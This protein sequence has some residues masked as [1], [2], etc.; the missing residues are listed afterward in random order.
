MR[1]QPGLRLQ[2]LRVARRSWRCSASISD[3]GREQKGPA[4]DGAACS[5]LQRADPQLTASHSLVAAP[6]AAAREQD[7]RKP[8]NLYLNA[9]SPALWASSR[10]FPSGSRPRLAHFAASRMAN[11]TEEYFVKV[12][13]GQLQCH[14]WHSS[15]APAELC[16]SCFRFL[17]LRLPPRRTTMIRYLIR[18]IQQPIASPAVLPTLQTASCMPDAWSCVPEHGPGHQPKRLCSPM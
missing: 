3:V 9:C 5:G 13:N 2:A 18:L 7:H 6:S 1:P 17:R 8:Y 10:A 16:D 15:G 14:M 11:R 12:P 4:P